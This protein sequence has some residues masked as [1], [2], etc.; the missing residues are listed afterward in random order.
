MSVYHD[1]DKYI[2]QGMVKI[3]NENDKRI[4]LLPTYVV[5][6]TSVSMIEAEAFDAAFDFLPKLFAQMN[7]SAVV[8]DK[9]RV[10][11]ITFDQTAQ[12][13]FP[14]GTREEL[15]TWLDEK[16]KNPI[17]PDGNSTNYGE[18]FKKLRIEIEE[19]V[20]QIESESYIDENYTENYTAYRPVVFFITDGHPNDKISE[21][22]NAYAKLTDIGFKARPNI[23]C[24]GVGEAK[25]DDLKGYG[26][27][28][29]KSS[30]GKYSTANSKLVLVSRDGVSP[31]VAL[32]EVI[33]ALVQS[34]VTSI[35]GLNVT[36]SE[37]D[38]EYANIFNGDDI[39]EDIDFDV[40][41]QVDDCLAE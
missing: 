16:E 34:I 31:A 6:D 15:K 9:L 35:A 41:E 11:V 4:A 14:L 21:R 25:I 22:N 30:S 17:Q 12:V 33:P 23:I 27:G 13:V 28:S 10:E 1:S 37:E 39:F 5:I 20:Q 40:F 19:G 18:V 32:S 26:A 36:S 29:Y 2:I 7:K 24:V 3:M 8:A 38:N